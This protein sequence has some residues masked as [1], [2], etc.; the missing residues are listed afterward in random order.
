MNI[1]IGF[2]LLLLVSLGACKGKASSV[3]E[4]LFSGVIRVAVDET[5]SPL[6]EEAINVFEAQ[7]NQAGVIPL[8]TSEVEAINL[9]LRDS[10]RWVLASRPLTE[11]ELESFH[12]KKFFPESVKVATDGIALIVNRQNA[13]SIFNLALLQKIFT[14]EITRWEEI[15]PGSRAGEIQVVF[16]H[17][18]SSTVRYVLDS[19][20]PDRKLS[21]CLRAEK[22]N[23]RVIDYVAQN[24][25]AMGVVGVSWLQNPEDSTNLSFLK[26]VKVLGVSRHRPAMSFNSFKPWQAYLALKEYPLI[27]D[28][29]VIL[30]D[31]RQGLASGFTGFLTS[32]RGQRII[33]KA[34]IVPATQPVRIVNVKE[35]W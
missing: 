11:N 32:D 28:V 14:G 6:A 26:Q 25:E 8:Y 7:Y 34:G 3:Q 24:P 30:T 5:L 4:T 1:R 19:L 17:P 15:A 2:W 10:V 29:Y 21:D 23:R 20:C 22:T 9:L 13:D 35:K 18:N 31:P 16:D 33:L 27:R 12:S